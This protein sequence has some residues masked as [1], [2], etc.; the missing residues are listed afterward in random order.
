MVSPAQGEQLPAARS[1]T[2]TWGQSFRQAAV[3]RDPQRAPAHFTL[4]DWAERAVSVAGLLVERLHSHFTEDGLNH[5]ARS[6][7]AHRGSPHQ[8]ASPTST[9]N[10]LRP[11]AAATRTQ[12]RPR[13][14]H[15][16]PA[17]SA[18][19]RKRAGESVGGGL[20]GGVCAERVA[21][22]APGRDPE[23]GSASFSARPRTL[24][25]VLIFTTLLLSTQIHQSALTRR[26]VPTAVPGGWGRAPQSADP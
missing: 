19:G 24:S 1:S 14:L 3:Q 5:A 25:H 11:Q 15:P 10:P 23:Q 26:A 7:R 21:A 16:A 20:Q 9:K 17:D 2:E 6:A 4:Q 22:L 12:A 8:P 18:L 13:R